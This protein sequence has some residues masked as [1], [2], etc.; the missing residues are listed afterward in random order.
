MDLSRLKKVLAGMSVAAM[1]LSQVGTVLAYSDVPGGSWYKEAVDAFVEAGYLDASQTRFRGGDPANRAEFVKLIVELN[2]GI[3]STPPAVRSFDDVMSSAW[4]YGYMEE[5]GKEG[6]VRGDKN[7]YGSHPCYA[8]PGSNINRAEA[9]ALIVRAF[10]LESTGDAPQFVDNPSGQWYTE[11]IQTAADHCVLQGD[12]ATKRVRPADNMNRAEMVVMLHRVDQGLTYGVDCG[13]EDTGGEPMITD[14]TAT[15][16]TTVEVEFNVPL[17]ADSAEDKSNYTVT[18]GGEVAITSVTLTDDTTVEVTL[19]EAMDSDTDYTLAVSDLMT[20]EGDTFSDSVTFSGYSALPVGEGTLEISVASSNPVGDTVPKGAN[21]VNMLSL[22]LTASCE[23]DV[24]VETFTVL[25][26]G[27]GDVNDIDGV[28]AAVDGGRISRRR[29]IDTQD[30]TADLRLSTPLTVKACDSVTVDIVAD[31]NSTAVTSAEHNLVVELASDVISNAKEVSGNFPLRGNTFR[32]A[33]VTSGKLTATYRTVAPDEA[34]VGDKQVVVGKFELG[35]DSVEDQTIYSMTFEQN[36]SAGDGDATNLAIRR[37]DGTVLTNAVAST[38]GDF[39]TVVFDPPFTI[40]EGDKI[41]LEVVGDIEGGAGDTLIMH[42]EESSDIFSVG[43]LYGYGVNGQ[44]YG[45]QISLPTETSTLPDTVTIDAGEFTIEIDGPVQTAF[46]RDDN[47]AVLANVIFTT[48]EGTVDIRKLFMAVEAETSTGG[49]LAQGSSSA[50]DTVAEVVEDVEMRNTKTGRTIDAIRLTGSADSG[51]DNNEG[52]WQIYRFDDITVNGQEKWEVRVD[53]ID[54]GSTNH[55]FG[56]DQFRVHFC[57]EP[58]ELSS[59]ANSTTCTFGGLGTASTAY[60]MEIEGLS[61]GDK[62]HDVR[63]RG[64][65]AGNFMRIAGAELTIAV[66]A[67]GTADTAVKNAKNINLM[68]FEARAGEA[69]DLLLTKAVFAAASG[70]LNN[71]QN[72][73]LWVDS[74]GDSKVDQIVQTGVAAQSSKVTFNDLIGGG[75]VIPKQQTVFFEVHTN[76]AATL[77]NDDLLLRFSTADADFIEVEEVDD[78]SSLSNIKLDGTCTTSPCEIIV[79]TVTSKNWNLASQGDLFVTKDS[80]PLRN[81]Q[82]LGGTLC[83]AVLRLQFHAENEAVDVTDLQFNSSGSTAG[84]VDRLELYKEGAS[85]YF[86]LATIG[87]CGSDDVLAV[88][89]TVVPG[90]NTGARAS[91]AFCANLDGRQLVVPEGS[92]M[93]VIVRP[94][95]KTDVQGGTS[96]NTVA[97]FVTRDPFSNNTTGSGAVRARGDESSNNLSANDADGTAE[98][99]VFIGTATVA[100]NARINGNNN[101]SVLAKITSITNANPDANG[102]AVP[103]GVSDIGQFKI[104]AAAHSNSNNGLNDVVLSGVIFNVTATNVNMAP[105]GFIFFNKANSTVTAD[106]DPWFTSS[107]NEITGTASG[108]FLVRC[109]S[110]LNSSVATDIDQG[111]DMTFVLQANITNPDVTGANTSTVQ[112]SLQQFDSITLTDFSTAATTASHFSWLD[113]DN[114]TTEF[115]WIEYPE[116]TVKSTSYQS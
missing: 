65:I 44:L 111:A 21:G 71:G 35:S 24:V 51:A 115:Q 110:L 114:G 66:K 6:W 41:T 1:T 90:T 31:L 64:N 57:G 42:F 92:D 30:Q 93:D 23:D 10:G 112:V 99:E 94:R 19:G 86:A 9:G 56:G 61:T 43:S 116:T 96:N 109:E 105:S 91:Q 14:A 85:T 88:N 108:S 11:D 52:T 87:G 38:V 79:T 55:P 77:T 25:H 22:D 80:T 50:K 97:F 53:F 68:R 37:T 48:G 34:E 73:T 63:P 113:R 49:T 8:R 82:C 101:V 107:T 45:S 69:E 26:E 47:D 100:T 78:G 103:T 29:T 74:D 2:G 60:Q 33:A 72:Y 46:T 70:S 104:A 106:C 32:V 83:E 59:G 58:T 18:A 95:M 16:A 40:L 62:V 20:K 102:T 3:L 28:Y 27:F 89:P 7:C 84:S 5:A 98:G 76:V 12:D 15:S 4:Y 67:I 17:D 54:N 81:R 39:F 13:T 36:G 75:F